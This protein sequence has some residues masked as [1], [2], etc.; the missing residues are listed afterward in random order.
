MNSPRE[1]TIE[2]RSSH[3]RRF[4]VSYVSWPLSICFVAAVAT[5]CT[6]AMA[7][8]HG[9]VPVLHDEFSNLLVADTLRHG[10]LANPPP[11]IW[12]PFQ[13][14][15]VVVRPTYASKYP[16]GPG[17]L[18]ALGWS[19]CGTP[20]AG[21]WIGAALCC[22]AITWAAGGCL[23]RRWAMLAGLLVALNSNVHH[24]WSLSFMNGWSTATASALVAGALLRLRKGSSKLDAF[25]LGTGIGGLALTRP[26]EGLIFTAAAGCLALW[27]WRGLSWSARLSRI[28]RVALWSAAPI[29][30]ALLLIAVQNQTI[31]GKVTTMAYQLH[32]SQYGVA[33]LN[34]FQSQRIPE[35]N[36]WLKDVPPS[37]Q[38]YH[39]GWSL[40]SYLKRNHLLGWCGAIAER[41]HV[42]TKLWGW[43][44]CLMTALVLVST[45]GRYWPVAGTIGLALLVG[46]FIPWYFSHY[47][48]PSLVWL[49]I[50]TAIAL[51][52]TIQR[53]TSDRLTMKLAVGCL[54]VLQLVGMAAEITAANRRAMTW[55]DQRQSL[56][57]GLRHSGDRHL[58][59]VRYHPNHNVHHEWV[60]NEAD[61][62][63]SA[64][65]WAH[66][67]R[68]D[69]DQRLLDHY[70][71]RKV[72]LLELDEDDHATVREMATSISTSVLRTAQ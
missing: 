63:N 7:W 49:V 21:I 31:T 32:E 27:W 69:L 47:F 12:Q 54:I 1:G 70:R 67:W 40:A 11:E 34:I 72:W 61:L 65:V 36:A 3:C 15:H 33:P 29:A 25:L 18:L 30:S 60:Y 14:F 6:L 44:Y 58:I 46:S 35:M 62:E 50:L 13:S 17:S 59:L 37:I 68:E 20:A 51:R 4:Y 41:L 55:A 42:V 19:L 64:V 45:R 8:H 43:A 5:A 52:V 53:F 56:V 9:P 71:Q 38:T 22:A 16:L 10:R 23:P 57:D 28:L 2:S 24:A 66:S 39:Y 26:A 48:A